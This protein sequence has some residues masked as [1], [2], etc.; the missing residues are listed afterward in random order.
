MAGEALA[1]AAVVALVD[2]AL[3]AGELGQA[4]ALLGP[5][6]A[7]QTRALVEAVALAAP[8]SHGQTSVRH[9]HTHTRPWLQRGFTKAFGF[10]KTVLSMNRL[11]VIFLYSCT[12]ILK[13]PV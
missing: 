8:C 10:E 2:L 6:L 9:T 13:S 7:Q 4:A 1:V 12:A 3:A 11:I 5:V